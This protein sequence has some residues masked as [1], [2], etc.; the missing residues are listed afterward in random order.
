MIYYFDETVKILGKEQ[1]GSLS[2]IGFGKT[3]YPHAKKKKKKT[4]TEQ[5][6]IKSGLLSCVIYKNKVK[7]D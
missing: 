1:P 5:Q 6:H 3:R 4:K 2:I 7:T